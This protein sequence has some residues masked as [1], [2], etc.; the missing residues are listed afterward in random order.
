MRPSIIGVA[1]G[2]AL[3]FAGAFGGFGAFVLVAILGAIGLVA[4]LVVEGKLDLMPER[5][6]RSR[7]GR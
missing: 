1:S 4:G 7:A 5:G 2:F 3:G 6:S